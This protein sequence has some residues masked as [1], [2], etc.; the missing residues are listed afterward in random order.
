MGFIEPAGTDR[1]QSP[2]A[3]VGRR[4]SLIVVLHSSMVGPTNDV[5]DRM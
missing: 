2:T 3:L 1:A 5:H 4:M